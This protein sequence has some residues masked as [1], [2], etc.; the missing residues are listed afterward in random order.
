MII[1]GPNN[2]YQQQVNPNST[3]EMFNDFSG[4][5]DNTN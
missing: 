2:N 3:Y 4:N 1:A 5:N